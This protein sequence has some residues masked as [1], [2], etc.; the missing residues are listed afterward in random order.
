MKKKLKLDDLIN[1]LRGPVFWIYTRADETS[2][3]EA[4]KKIA[5]R[6]KETFRE[7]FI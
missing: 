7:D 5:N 4:F 2:V 3:G 1:W 6:M